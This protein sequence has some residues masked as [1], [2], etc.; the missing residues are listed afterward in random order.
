MSIVVRREESRPSGNSCV[1]ACEAKFQDDCFAVSRRGRRCPA[2]FRHIGAAIFRCRR[3]DQIGNAHIGARIEKL[4][5]GIAKAVG[6]GRDHSGSV[7]G[8]GGRGSRCAI[9]VQRRWRLI[10]PAVGLSAGCTL[11]ALAG[12]SRVRSTGKSMGSL[13]H[14]RDCAGGRGFR[15]LAIDGLAV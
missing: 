2:P 7:P 11:L 1:L 12:V 14:D 5:A 3:K 8:H 9:W 15:D 6:H 4:P 10:R 13:L